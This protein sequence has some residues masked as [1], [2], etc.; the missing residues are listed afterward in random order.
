MDKANRRIFEL[1][2]K[3]IRSDD[4]FNLKNLF[5]PTVIRKN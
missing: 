3:T 2:N 1:G 4:W 5:I